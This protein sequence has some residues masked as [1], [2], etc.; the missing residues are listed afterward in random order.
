ML[1]ERNRPDEKLTRKQRETE[2]AVR[3]KPRG[4]L[5][6]GDNKGETNEESK[7]RPQQRTKVAGRSPD[8]SLS[9]Q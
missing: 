7:S 2:K 9:E 6:K 5:R 1:G 4:T 8:K 3:V